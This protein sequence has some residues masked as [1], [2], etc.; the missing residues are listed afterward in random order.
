GVFVPRDH[1]C[2]D[3]AARGC[4]ERR[5]GLQRLRQLLG[6]G[7]VQVLLVFTTNR[8]YRK[9]YKALQFV[10]E[11]VVERGIRCLFVKYGVD[12]AD[13]KRWRPLLQLCDRIPRALCKH[14]LALLEGSK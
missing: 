7:G 12:S 1:I 8:L 3:L 9:T 14:W 5:P 2:F 11:E 4:K 10:E 6:S 13:E